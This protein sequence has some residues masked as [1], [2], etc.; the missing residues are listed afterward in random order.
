MELPS[1]DALAL[2][3]T[4]ASPKPQLDD[5]WNAGFTGSYFWALTSSP[6]SSGSSATNTTHIQARM[7]E[8]ALEDPATGSAACALACHLA[9]QKGKSREQRFE[10]CQGV[11]MG[12]KSDI[13]VRVTL[14]EALDAV[15]KVV[16]SGAAV[17]VMEGTVEC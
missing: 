7:I 10:I 5:A 11:E 17:Q 13:G 9:L 4:G 2:V 14:T 16:L 1:L 12:R 15:E 6:T 8:G 3:S